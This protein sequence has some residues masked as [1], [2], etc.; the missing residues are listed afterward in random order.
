MITSPHLDRELH[1]FV[2]WLHKIANLPHSA[3][4]TPFESC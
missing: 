4:C 2:K 1:T 3:I